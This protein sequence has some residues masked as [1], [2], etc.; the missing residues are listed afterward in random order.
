MK[1]RI[2]YKTFYVDCSNEEEYPVI[3][4]IERPIVQIKFFFIWHSIKKFV[5]YDRED[6]KRQAEKLYNCLT[7]NNYEL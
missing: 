7:I 1:C 6:A 4:K 2:I 5:N 3:M